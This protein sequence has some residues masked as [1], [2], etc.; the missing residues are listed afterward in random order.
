MTTPKP[1]KPSTLPEWPLP[2]F[3]YFTHDA[4]VNNWPPNWL[5]QEWGRDDAAASQIATANRDRQ[6]ELGRPGTIVGLSEKSDARS[7]ITSAPG[8]ME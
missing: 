3:P 6:L 2:Y 5:P 1:R 7:R 8:W 4:L